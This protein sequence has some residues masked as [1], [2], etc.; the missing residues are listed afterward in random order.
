MT[1]VFIPLAALAA[2]AVPVAAH[3]SFS[4]FDMKKEMTLTGEVKEFQWTNP[5]IWV[6]LMAPGADGKVVEWSIEGNSPST[7]SRTGW[8]KRSVAPGDKVSIVIHPLRDGQNGGS[9]VKIVRE[10]GT[11]VGENKVGP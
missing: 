1:K 4:M 10:D 2:I 5:H 11:V 3:H 7:L 6:Q 8:S 9:L